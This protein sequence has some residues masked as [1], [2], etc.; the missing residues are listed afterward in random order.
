MHQSQVISSLL[1]NGYVIDIALVHLPAFAKCKY[2]ENLWNQTSEIHKE[3][4]ERVFPKWLMPMSS[5][6]SKILFFSIN[7]LSTAS[8]LTYT[9]SHG[10]HHILP[11]MET[12]KAHKPPGPYP[13][14]LT[15]HFIYYTICWHKFPCSGSIGHPRVP[16]HVQGSVPAVTVDT[17]TP[18]S[19][20]QLPAGCPGDS[21]AG[22]KWHL[23]QIPTNATSNN[24]FPHLQAS[25]LAL[26]ARFTIFSL[27]GTFSIRW[28]RNFIKAQHW[29]NSSSLWRFSPGK[30]GRIDSRLLFPLHNAVVFPTHTTDLQGCFILA[31]LFPLEQHIGFNVC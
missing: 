14:L 11:C 23:S 3:S 9:H 4:K 6:W 1:L 29:F 19:G 17:L 12:H 24:L 8:F 15:V 26:P 31:L 20:W 13:Y 7:I 22:G 18:S 16:A 2:I 21:P 28:A 5:R 25:L 10:V 27:Q 30:S